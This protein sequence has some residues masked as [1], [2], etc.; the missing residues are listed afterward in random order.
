MTPCHEDL[1]GRCVCDL[2]DDMSVAS[3]QVFLPDCPVCRA[4]TKKLQVLMSL[5]GLLWG[6][7]TPVDRSAMSG[8]LQTQDKTSSL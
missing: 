1:P 5:G 6:H 4:H 2:E 3:L 8:T 7:S